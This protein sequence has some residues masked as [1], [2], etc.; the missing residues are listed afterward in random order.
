MFSS[1][2]TRVESSS[3]EEDAVSTYIETLAIADLQKPT[4]SQSPKK[5]SLLLPMTSLYLIS[6]NQPSLKISRP[7]HHSHS[8]SNIIK[9]HKAY[10]PQS[11]S[12]PLI[13]ELESSSFEED[14]VSTYIEQLAIADL[15][16]PTKSQIPKKS[17]PSTADDLLYLI[18]NQVMVL[19]NIRGSKVEATLEH[20]VIN[21]KCRAEFIEGILKVFLPLTPSMDSA[22]KVH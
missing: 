16:K 5:S 21:R 7:I 6:L 13:Q 4:K 3:F 15:Q 9:N 18:K 19:D 20:P 8:E 11:N 12:A 22:G 10:T 2:N 17:S 1:I 14:A